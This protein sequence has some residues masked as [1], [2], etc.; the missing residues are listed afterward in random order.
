MAD[1]AAA[2]PEEVHPLPPLDMAE[3]QEYFGRL[4]DVAR[5]RPIT[6]REEFLFGQLLSQF[7]QAC[8]AEAKGYKGRCY[9]IPEEVV[10][11]LIEEGQ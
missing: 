3:C 4:L 2:Q 10:T 8:W 1:I 7:E 9:V 5:Q 6:A 11:R